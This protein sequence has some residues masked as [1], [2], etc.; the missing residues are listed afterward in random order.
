MYLFNK[1]VFNTLKVH[2]QVNAGVL[3][4]LFIH[5]A[6]FIIKKL[7]IHM[8]KLWSLY[9]YCENI[10]IRYSNSDCNP[11]VFIYVK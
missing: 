10:T 6:F 1:L 8:L 7:L 11:I 4:R 5:F 9:I 2:N 3:R